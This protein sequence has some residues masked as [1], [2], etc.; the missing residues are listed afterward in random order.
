MPRLDPTVPDPTGL[1]HPVPGCGRWAVAPTSAT[2]VV[3]VPH[4]TP[5]RS[6]GTERSE[7]TS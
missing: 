5:W 3:R 6:P 7:E 2:A 4:S 1:D